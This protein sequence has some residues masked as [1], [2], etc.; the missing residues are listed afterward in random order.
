M[1]Q[2]EDFALVAPL[3]SMASN[4]GG[5]TV[6]SFGG[7]AFKDRRGMLVNSKQQRETEETS[8]LTYRWSKLRWLFMD[9][10][11][12]TGADVFGLLSENLRLNVPDETV[13]GV[14]YKFEDAKNRAEN[15]LFAQSRSH[16]LEMLITPLQNDLQSSI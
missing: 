15:R 7:I 1:E 8:T 14:N 9:E 10:I 6:H 13:D 2:G 5:S 12:A 4:I 11:E 16:R 3:N